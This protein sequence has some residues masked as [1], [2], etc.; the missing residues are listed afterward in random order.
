MLLATGRNLF[1]HRIN[2]IP[3][4]ELQLIC[5]FTYHVHI[6]LTRYARALVARVD[7][8]SDETNFSVH[9]QNATAMMIPDVLNLLQEDPHSTGPHHDSFDKR[10][11]EPLAFSV[12]VAQSSV[13]SNEYT[14]TAEVD[15]IVLRTSISDLLLLRQ[16]SSA[17]CLPEKERVVTDGFG[18]KFRTTKVLFHS[19]KLG[20]ALRRN[21]SKIIV[22]N[23]NECRNDDLQQGDCIYAINGEVVFDDPEVNISTVVD[24]LQSRKR[25]ISITFCRMIA[26]DIRTDPIIQNFGLKGDLLLTGFSIVIAETDMPLFC[27]RSV[28]STAKFSRDLLP[29]GEILKCEISSCLGLEYYNLRIWKWEPL[30]APCNLF[31]S[32]SH[33]FDKLRGKDIVIETG[34]RGNSLDFTSSD[35]FFET[36][37]RAYKR[38]NREAQINQSQFF[39]DVMDVEQT[40]SKL[41]DSLAVKQDNGS[42]RYFIFRNRS[43]ISLAFARSIH[44]GRK[45]E[46][47]RKNDL[48]AIGGYLGMGAYDSSEVSIVGSGEDLPFSLNVEVGAASGDSPSSCLGLTVAVQEING[49]SSQPFENLQ[50]V[51]TNEAVLALNTIDHNGRE[52]QNEWVTWSVDHLDEKCIVTMGTSLRVTSLIHERLEIGVLCGSLEAVP[53]QHIRRLANI[54]LGDSYDLP[55]WLPLRKIEWHCY[56]RLNENAPFNLLFSVSKGRKVTLRCSSDGKI[57]CKGASSS[58]PSDWVAVYRQDVDGVC[59]IVVDS[60][61]SIRNL[62][63]VPIDWQVR[64]NHSAAFDGSSERSSTLATGCFADVLCRQSESMLL[65]LRPESKDLQWSDWTPLRLSPPRHPEVQSSTSIDDSDYKL[66]VHDYLKTLTIGA[67]VC[68]KENGMDV[69]LYCDLW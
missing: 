41:A 11:L 4:W 18:R 61:I 52:I 13:N 22:E 20:I 9:I 33:H 40:L 23:L 30:L 50:L 38:L 31:V 24:R 7:H 51:R 27:F 44:T 29:D 36:L 34:D 49:I 10:L 25:P 66:L 54:S 53:S 17:L 46:F 57:A 58:S 62:L 56:I 42:Q 12:E 3:G 19:E 14:C 55:L 1:V 37:Q 8:E 67:R 45:E 69:V 60:S 59:S 28:R 39:H 65:R 2:L 16:L 47:N 32:L 68:R 48:C 6:L 35:A 15:P 64:D 5:T 21:D 63:P 43:G 26:D